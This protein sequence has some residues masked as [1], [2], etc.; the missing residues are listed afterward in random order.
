MI[1]A[2]EKP[3]SEETKPHYDWAH[4]LVGRRVSTGELFG[5]GVIRIVENRASHV[6]YVDL[7]NG[8]GGYWRFDQIELL[9]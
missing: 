6:A 4:P 9:T 1:V 8:I 5:D 2:A 7:D 3:R